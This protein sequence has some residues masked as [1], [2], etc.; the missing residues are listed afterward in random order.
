[1]PE[2]AAA[3]NILGIDPGL[4]VCGYGV[5]SLA[6]GAI[7]PALVE[8]G[9][10]RL[11]PK[12]SVAERLAELDAELAAI[13]DQARPTHLA[14][15]AVFSHY[16]HPRTAVLMAHARGV[17]LL[18]GQ[19]AGLTVVDLPPAEVKRAVV[20]SGRAGKPQVQRAVQAQLR[21]AEPPEPHDVADAL[22]IAL[23]LGRRL[24]GVLSQREDAKP[25]TRQ[26]QA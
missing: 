9:V 13:I 25:P 1:M 5:V 3:R 26:E 16:R 21:L 15:E 12:R 6:D 18:A 17:V 7:E 11:D 24:V 19:R 23:T 14:V 8:A 4:R 10:I 22:A 2:P 20:G